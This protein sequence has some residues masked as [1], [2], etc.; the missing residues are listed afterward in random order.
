[1]WVR[2]FGHLVLGLDVDLGY[3]ALALGA[4]SLALVLGLKS[5]LIFDS[6]STAIHPRYDYAIAYVRTADIPGVGCCTVT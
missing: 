4:K 2:G 3:Q 6:H 1:M 5:L